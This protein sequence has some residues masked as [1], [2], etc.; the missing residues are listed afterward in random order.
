MEKS[1]KYDKHSRSYLWTIS[2]EGITTSS[3][4]KEHSPFFINQYDINCVFIL[5]LFISILFSFFS[6]IDHLFKSLV[7]S[8]ALLVA[9]TFFSNIEFFFLFFKIFFLFCINDCTCITIHFNILT[10]VNWLIV[11][12]IDMILRSK[13]ILNKSINRNGLTNYL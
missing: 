6:D 11:L 9:F 10:V 2:P 1:F 8:S 4:R 7:V 13:D 12:N 5:V 3:F